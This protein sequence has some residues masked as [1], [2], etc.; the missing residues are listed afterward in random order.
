MIKRTIVGTLIGAG[1]LFGYGLYAQEKAAVS[2]PMKELF[3][4]VKLSKTPEAQAKKFLELAPQL[5]QYK[6]L[7]VT[8]PEVRDFFLDSGYIFNQYGMRGNNPV[9]RQAIEAFN[10]DVEI[11]KLSSI[12]L[13]KVAV[14]KNGSYKMVFKN[15]VCQNGNIY[16]PVQQELILRG[17]NPPFTRKTCWSIGKADVA[18]G[19]MKL[20]SSW[21]PWKEASLQYSGLNLTPFSVAD[22]IAAVGDEASIY[23]FPLAGGNAQEIKDLPGKQVMAVTILNDRVYAFAGKSNGNVVNET[24][25]FSCKFDGSDRQIHM[26]S[27]RDNKQNNLDREKPFWVNSMIADKKQNRLIFNCVSPNNSGNVTGLWEFNLL[28]NTGK[29]L[30]NI[31]Y[32]PIDPIMTVVDNRIF[33]S[34]FHDNHCIY[35]LNVDKGEVFFSTTN[36]AAKNYLKVKFRPNQGIVYSSPCFARDN[37]IWF[38]GDCQIKLLTLPDVSKSP[39]ILAPEGRFLPGFDRLLFPHP[40]GKSAIAVDEKNI[41]KITPKETGGS[42]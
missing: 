12:D 29:C 40:D 24:I 31:Q 2:R 11:R 22:K 26:S 28:T 21:S 39:L 32:K 17:S 1:T 23:L 7:A 13:I 4:D 16:L 10:R 25:L 9:F 30:F 42:K 8:D 27:S 14:P 37:Q 3:A 5:L 41:Y 33:F 18:T 6:S 38:G 15:A 34:F 20:I 19:A 36:A 35:D